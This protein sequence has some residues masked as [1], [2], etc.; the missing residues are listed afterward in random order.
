MTIEDVRRDNPDGFLK[1]RA[2]LRS[3]IPIP[4]AASTLIVFYDMDGT[5]LLAETMEPARFVIEPFGA[6][7]AVNGCLLRDAHTFKLF[8]IPVRPDPPPKKPD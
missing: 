8:V 6:V 5:P 7:A 3:N 2:R 1:I 4:I